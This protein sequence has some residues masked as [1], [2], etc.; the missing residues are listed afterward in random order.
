MKYEYR[1]LRQGKTESDEMFLLRVNELGAK[2]FRYIGETIADGGLGTVV[3][4]FAAA[5]TELDLR[6]EIIEANVHEG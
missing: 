2:G 1:V 3:M 4:E 6:G 5:I